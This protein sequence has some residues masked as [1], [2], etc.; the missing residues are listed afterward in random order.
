MGKSVS[1]RASAV[2]S[3]EEN[4]VRASSKSSTKEKLF[5]MKKQAITRSLAW[6]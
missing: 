5:K 4:I 1:Q 3:C 6:R 2:Q